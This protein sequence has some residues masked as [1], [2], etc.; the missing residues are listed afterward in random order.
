MWQP[1][2]DPGRCPSQQAP[3]SMTYNHKRA[4][5]LMVTWRPSNDD[6]CRSSHCPVPSHGRPHQQPSTTTNLDL[7]N[8]IR[9]AAP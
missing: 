8:L 2:D 9:L 3:T 6:G 5:S 7:I 1:K 4:T